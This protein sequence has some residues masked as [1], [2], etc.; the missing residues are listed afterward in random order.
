MDWLAVFGISLDDVS[1]FQVV[2][3]S[4]RTVELDSRV[5][6]PDAL[7]P[8][9]YDLKD[10]DL[11][12]PLVPLS[13]WVAIG[14]RRRID[15]V[16][17]GAKKTFRYVKIGSHD[18]LAF[19]DLLPGS[20]VRVREDVSALRHAP[21][22]KMPG[23][24]MFLVQHA[25]GIACSRLLRSE[26]DRIVLCS[27]HL[28]YAPLEVAVSGDGVVLGTV[29]AEIRAI[30]TVQ[31]AAVSAA[32]ERYQVPSL[33]SKALPARSVGEFIQR[34]RK[35]CGISFREAS[36]RT[37]VIARELGDRRYYCSPSALSDYETRKFAPRHVHKLISICAVYFARAADLLK[38]CGAA[39]D[40]AGAHAMPRDLLNSVPE[41]RVPEG[42]PSR[43]LGEMQR[44]FGRLPHFLRTA[45]SSMFGL[46]N[47]S[48][49]DVFWV[50]DSQE[51]KYSCL[52]GIQFLI[53]DRR[54]KRPRPS[55]SCPIWAQ[56]MYVL[57][58]RGGGYL[59]G[60]CRLEN[61]ALLLCSPAQRAK[62]VRLRTGVDAEVVGRVVG[63]IRKLD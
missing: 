27:R 31:K 57:Q 14:S 58:K 50:G 26:S 30:A 53:V 41:T 48:L 45:G 46:Q 4:L 28:P 24:T 19:P 33:F 61:G 21:I 35:A 16:S 25:K 63:V 12:M 34:A 38:A 39:L 44:R 17:R 62:Y 40:R 52:E 43:F 13:Q 11:S 47:L 5:Y 42:E 51:S 60:F 23:R 9:L 6:R 29:D 55:L 1:R 56:P 49:R 18:A 36:K 59:W 22:G 20:I 2:F 37:R 54:Q 10:P 8:W 32:L 7:T 15:S 3:P